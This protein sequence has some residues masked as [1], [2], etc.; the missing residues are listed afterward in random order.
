[1]ISVLIISFCTIIALGFGAAAALSDY[2]R[3]IIP[4]N[5]VMFITGSFVLAFITFLIFASDTT[6]FS[7]WK[8]HLLSGGLTFIIT[9]GLFHFKIIG[10]GDSK[11]LSVYA[12]WVGLSGLMPL[13][14][15]MAVVGGVLGVATLLLNKKKLTATPV[16]G[17]WIAK[18][19]SG[20]QEVPYGIAIFAGALVAFWSVG[21]LQPSELIKLAG[22]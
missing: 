21:Y 8:N 2:N 9:Y 7:S 17:S 16:E 20:T 13:F 12:L 5:F 4:N 10:G 11:L 1:M 18:A 15:F 6:F 22:G 3:L 19:Q 14:F